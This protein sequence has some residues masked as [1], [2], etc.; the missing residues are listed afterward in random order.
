MRQLSVLSAR[1]DASAR[2][3]CWQLKAASAAWRTST[4]TR[5]SVVWLCRANRASV[6]D[7]VRQD[8][9]RTARSHR[10]GLGET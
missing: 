6:S 9:F 5:R 7:T 10:A 2:P 3:A 1:G 8:L 4:H